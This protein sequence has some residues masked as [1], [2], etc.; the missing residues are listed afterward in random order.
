MRQL[1]LETFTLLPGVFLLSV[2]R[3]RGKY[4]DFTN[5]ELFPGES[6]I[7]RINHNTLVNDTKG[8]S[9]FVMCGRVLTQKVK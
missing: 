7:C 2:M 6:L 4:R 5:L 3:G 8:M 1:S 9:E